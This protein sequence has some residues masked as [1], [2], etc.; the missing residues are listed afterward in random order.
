MSIES[1]II[2]GLITGLLAGTV[3]AA[4]RRILVRALPQGEQSPSEHSD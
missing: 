2:I 3:A 4:S 1:L